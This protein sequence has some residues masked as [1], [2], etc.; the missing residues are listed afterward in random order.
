VTD[1]LQREFPHLRVGPSTVRTHGIPPFGP[2]IQRDLTETPLFSFIYAFNRKCGRSSL[3][4]A[5][6]PPCTQ[7]AHASATP[8]DNLYLS[9]ALV[10]LAPSPAPWNISS[11]NVSASTERNWSHSRHPRTCKVRA[12]KLTIAHDPIAL[13]RALLPLQ[14]LVYPITSR[15]LR[16]ICHSH[17]FCSQGVAF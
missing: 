8:A 7:H 11:R 14:I 2:F 4:I 5:R 10:S 16:G 3:A 17:Y 15:C 6:L 9:R 1:L 13:I 12:I